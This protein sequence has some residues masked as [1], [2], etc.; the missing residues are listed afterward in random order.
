MYTPRPANGHPRWVQ[1]PERSLGSLLST[2]RRLL[3]ADRLL[4][5]SWTQLDITVTGR[6]HVRGVPPGFAYHP[7]VIH[8][9]VPLSYSQGLLVS[10]DTPTNDSFVVTCKSVL[11]E[12]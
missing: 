4:M 8:H 12:H 6:L 7:R 9:S 10:V 5:L 11:K 1:L 2:I 3:G